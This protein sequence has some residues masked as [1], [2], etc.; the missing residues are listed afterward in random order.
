MMKRIFISV[1]LGVFLLAGC[2]ETQYR[3]SKIR[4]QHR[5]WDD[6]VLDKVAK[7]Q[8]EPDMTGDMVRAAIGLPEKMSRQ[9]DLEKWGYAVMVGDYEPKEK[10]VYFV[11]FKN[12]RVIRTEG[13]INKLKTLSWYE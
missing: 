10:F 4:V 2:A 6:Q 9:G 12:G 11:F 8:V 1:C 3:E 13:D 7:R 5:D